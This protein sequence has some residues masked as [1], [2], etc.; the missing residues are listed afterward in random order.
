VVASDESYPI[1]IAYFEAQQ[2]EEGFERVEAAIDK[3]T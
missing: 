1:G 2:E 3:V